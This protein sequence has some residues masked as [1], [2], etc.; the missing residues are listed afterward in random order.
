MTIYDAVNEVYRKIGRNVI[1]FQKLELLLKFIVAN[2]RFSG[3][4][5]D[6]KERIAQRANNINKQT[7]GT[8]VG[9]YIEHSNPAC[10]ESSSESEEKKGLFFSFGFRIECD[11]NYYET[12]K[13]ELARMVSERNEL[14][15]N[16]LPSFDINSL[17]SCDEIGKKL[18][19]QSENIRREIKELKYYA[20][21]LNE[22]RKEMLSF[23][24]SEQGKK[25]LHLAFSQESRLVW[26][27]ANAATQVKRPDGWALMSMA[28]QLVKHYAPEEYSQLKEK[29]GYKSLKALILAT[30]IFDVY[31]E[32]T[33]EGGVRV[34]YRLKSGWDCSA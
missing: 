7:M 30:D 15:H 12:K 6:L 34:L 28:G 20:T 31:E 24:A 3:T 5:E 8:L 21:T 26:M 9:H 16:L 10:E 32:A 23:Y 17:E 13:K 29:Y 1:L 25:Q 4:A 33:E 14:I 19:D 11:S 27:L 18:D 2:G 22:A